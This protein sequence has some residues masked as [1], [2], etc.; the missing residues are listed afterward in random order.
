M[1]LIEILLMGYIV[2]AIAWYIR[3]LSKINGLKR[4]TRILMDM[5]LLTMDKVAPEYI[6]KVSEE[7]G[8][9]E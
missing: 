6:E 1:E 2:L 5:M 8:N 4:D 9:I 7:Y 3:L